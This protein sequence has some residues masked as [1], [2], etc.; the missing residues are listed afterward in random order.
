MTELD[1][2]APVRAEANFDVG[3][4][5]R[6]LRERHPTLEGTPELF[7]FGKG[8]SNLTYLARYG[9]RELVIRRAPPGIRIKSAHDMGREF[10]ILRA[11]APIWPK[12]P[13]PVAY[14]EDEGVIGSEFYAMNRVEG[15]ILRAR[16]ADAGPPERDGL[17]PAA[18]RRVSEAW[19]DTLAEIH[20]LDW[21]AAGLESLGKPA[22]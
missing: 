2:P 22:G 15:V 20:S 14:C 9:Q 21:R 13:R 8:F 3:A 10:R 17:G 4:L 11:L 7:Q 16:R 6:W 5:A 19:C 18:M 12:V 1:Q